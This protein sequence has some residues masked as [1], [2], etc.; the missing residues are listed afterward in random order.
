VAAVDI[1]AM[2]AVLIT[3][4]YADERCWYIQALTVNAMSGYCPAAQ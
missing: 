3:T 1:Q 4:G 2:S